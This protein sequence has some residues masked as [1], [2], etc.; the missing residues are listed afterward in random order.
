MF[1]RNKKNQKDYKELSVYLHHY[2]VKKE[3]IEAFQNKMTEIAP[4]DYFLPESDHVYYDYNEPLDLELGVLSQI[5]QYGLESIIDPVVCKPTTARKIYGPAPLCGPL[6]L[7]AKDFFY[8]RVAAY[9]LTSVGPSTYRAC[10]AAYCLRRLIQSQSVRIKVVSNAALTFYRVI[11]LGV[12]DQTMVYDPFINPTKV[13]SEKFHKRNISRLFPEEDVDEENDLYEFNVTTPVC[14]E[15][16]ERLGGIK[17]AL[18][19]MLIVQNSVDVWMENK[20]YVDSLACLDMLPEDHE[21]STEYALNYLLEKIKAPIAAKARSA[22]ATIDTPELLRPTLERLQVENVE[23]EFVG[24]VLPQEPGKIVLSGYI[25]KEIDDDRPLAETVYD[26][27][28]AEFIATMKANE[29]QKEVSMALLSDVI[30]TLQKRGIDVASRIIASDDADCRMWLDAAMM[31][32]GCGVRNSFCMTAYAAFMIDKIFYAAAMERN[33]WDKIP[34]ITVMEAGFA[35]RYVVAIG[36]VKTGEWSIYDP[37]LDASRVMTIKEYEQEVFVKAGKSVGV[38]N[39]CM[40]IGLAERAD[41]ARRLRDEAY[42]KQESVAYQEM[43]QKLKI[44][45]TAAPVLPKKGDSAFGIDA[46]L[47]KVFKYAKPISKDVEM[48]SER[49]RSP[50]M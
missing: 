46:M 43:Q 16:S 41:F 28:L 44:V 34:M 12:G 27:D 36:R 50:R 35:G 49:L 13:F 7:A 21:E 23:N 10:Y 26:S 3:E 14:Q 30:D 11:I 33:K 25:A 8:G 2:G 31:F 47:D 42:V 19:A 29:K 48:T 40:L 17:E 24:T 39:N 37:L 4:A 15:L 18:R 5:V 6:E 22:P 45:F 38:V 9:D 1:D 32:L 20:R